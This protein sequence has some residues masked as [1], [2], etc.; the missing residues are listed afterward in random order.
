MS[1]QLINTNYSLKQS[2]DDVYHALKDLDILKLS[3]YFLDFSDEKDAVS[4]FCKYISTDR[5]EISARNA[6][7]QDLISV[8]DIGLRIKDIL[9]SLSSLE[10]FIKKSQVPAAGCIP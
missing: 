9:S 7:F 8:K 2:S 6:V 10:E 4:W 5:N 1:L 3:D